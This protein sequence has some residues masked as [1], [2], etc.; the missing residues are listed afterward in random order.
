MSRCGAWRV[1]LSGFPFVPYG[2]S[3]RTGGE[4]RHGEHTPSR[5]S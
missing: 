4:V 5:Y 2:G 3:S 1:S